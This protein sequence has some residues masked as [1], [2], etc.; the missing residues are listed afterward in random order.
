MHMIRSWTATGVLLGWRRTRAGPALENLPVDQK[1]RDRS[2]QRL[3]DLLRRVALHLLNGL[4]RIE[5]DMPRHGDAGDPEEGMVGGQRL[6]GEDVEPCAAKPAIAQRLH[7]RRL[8]DHCAAGGV[9]ED[10][11]WF[12]PVERLPADEAASL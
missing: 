5:T 11:G 10:S 6:R 3:N 1:L 12:H 2:P 7:E 8:V 9:H 4:F